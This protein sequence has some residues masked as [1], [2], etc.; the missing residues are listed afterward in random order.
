MA[1]QSIV[2]MHCKP[3]AALIDLWYTLFLNA[4][5]CKLGWIVFP[6]GKRAYWWRM[7]S[8]L[9]LCDWVTPSAVTMRRFT[10]WW[11]SIP[12]TSTTLSILAITLT[13]L[14]AIPPFAPLSTNDSKT[15]LECLDTSYLMKCCLIILFWDFS[16]LGENSI[17]QMSAG[18][19]KVTAWIS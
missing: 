6:F 11:L 1:Y 15:F 14:P 2:W 17:L 5:I 18:F 12:V 7:T 4:S 10:I 16:F 13:S 8:I 9:H 19:F 3:P